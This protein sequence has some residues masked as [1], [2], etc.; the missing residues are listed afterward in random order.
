M[1]IITL[2]FQRP[3]NVSAQKGDIAYFTNDPDGEIISKIGEIISISRYV[4]SCYIS[5]AA[6][7]PID[8]SFILFSKDN[9]ANLTSLTGYYLKVT[10]RNDSDEYAELFSVGT[11][12]FESSK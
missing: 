9:K 5:P 8:S 12:V 1:D 11:E 6:E 4:M 2:T 3:I 7:R 10:M